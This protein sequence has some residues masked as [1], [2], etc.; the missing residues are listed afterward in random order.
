MKV[1]FLTGSLNP[2]HDGVGDYTQA[3]ASACTKLGHTTWCGSVSDNALTEPAISKHLA[4]YP[5]ALHRKSEFTSLIE[6]LKRLHPDW[7]SLQYVPYSFHPRGFVTPL[8]KVIQQLAPQAKL[9]IMFHEV[10]IGPHKEASLKEKI[11]GYYQRYLLKK[12]LAKRRPHVA[13]TH[14]SPY[15]HLL[16]DIGIEAKTL[17]LFSSISIAEGGSRSWVIQ[18]LKNLG[19]KVNT[20]STWLI[21]IFG[22]LY[23]EWNAEPLLHYLTQA[24]KAAKRESVIISF[25]NLGAGEHAWDLLTHKAKPPIRTARIGMLEAEDVSKLLQ[26][27]DFGIAAPPW[28]LIEK[29]STVAAMLDHG[30]PVI[31]NRD[32]IH[33]NFPC[34]E[35]THPFLIKMDSNLP[36]AMLKAHKKP[37]QESVHTIA[38]K[39]LNDLK[40]IS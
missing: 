10:W 1:A 32:D 22:S 6:E 20:S 24:C 18:K 11:T 33:F 7:L 28:S 12:M 25:G 16:R 39:F 13:H 26:G 3:L 2:G 15:M 40:S 19:I 5:H 9:H 37:P 21:G 29:G 4:R 30:L 38:Q 17:P 14:A 27:L 31:V 8:A 35:P 34:P 23:S 36:Q